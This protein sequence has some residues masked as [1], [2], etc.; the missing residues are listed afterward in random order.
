MEYDSLIR[1]SSE[2][3]S[4]NPS[5]LMKQYNPH[6]ADVMKILQKV[7]RDSDKNFLNEKICLL[8]H[9]PF[10]VHIADS[11]ELFVFL[12]FDHSI[13]TCFPIA[14]IKSI[15]SSCN[16]NNKKNIKV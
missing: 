6:Y 13:Y 3:Y 9:L 15:I 16:A 10:P 14:K 12:I 8:N 2:F 5:N 7:I 11:S 4:A 1:P